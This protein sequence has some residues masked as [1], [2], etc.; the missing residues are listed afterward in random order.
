MPTQLLKVAV[1]AAIATIGVLAGCTAKQETTPPAANT[2]APQAAPATPTPKKVP[3]VVYVPTPQVVVD[4]MLEMAKVGKDDVLYDLGS[5]DGRIVITAAEKFGTRGTGIEI[6]PK[7]VK[8]AMANAEK[9][10]VTDQVQFLEQD[11]F[12]TDISKATVV[13]LYLLP[14][15][16]LRLRPTLLRTLK[17]GT[18]IV[19]HD[20]AMGIWNPERIERVKGPRREHTVGLWVVPEKV[21]PELLNVEAELQQLRQ[22]QTPTAQPTQQS[23]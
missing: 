18:R 5:G 10:K 12:Q 23:P 17:P 13:T 8:Q 15:L 11:L 1:T 2:P 16:N 3:D 4:K 22:L 7:L 21:P 20:F 9:A 6:D 14:E 19:S